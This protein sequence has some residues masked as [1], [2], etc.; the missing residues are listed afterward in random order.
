MKNKLENPKRIA[1]LRPEETLKKVGLQ[2]N[3]V[4]CD[5]GA[6]SGIFTI[7]AAK[8][9]KNIVYALEI[10][11]E[12]LLLIEEKAKNA[13]LSNIQTVKVANNQFNLE[14]D[15]VDIV[16]MV[17]VLH[18]INDKPVILE[19][20]KKILK[21]DGKLVIIE[22][23]KQDTSMGPPAAH[24]L[25]QAEVRDLCETRGLAIRERFVL[26]DNFY[27]LVFTKIEKFNGA[28]KYSR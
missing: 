15:S 24:R 6:G 11:P 9:T 7:P 8:I 1:E 13:G 20:I 23:H 14:K 18:E 3:H 26:G 22:F 27:C 28:L 10:N 17:T 16:L 2:E 21:D 4:L 5:V 19:Q 12:M 25:S